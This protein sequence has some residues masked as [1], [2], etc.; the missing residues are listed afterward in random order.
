MENASVYTE[1]PKRLYNTEE[2]FLASALANG[3]HI[4]PFCGITGTSALPAVLH[5]PGSDWWNVEYIPERSAAC[6]PRWRHF[7]SVLFY[8]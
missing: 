8:F 4:W 1:N 2:T 6:Y 3:F 7:G 5:I